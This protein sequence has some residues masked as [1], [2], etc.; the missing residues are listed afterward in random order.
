M[1][2]EKL[3]ILV[4]D[5]EPETRWFFN[6]ELAT[7]TGDYVTVVEDKP[8]ALE[9]LPQISPDVVVV[10]VQQDTDAE[11][12][13]FLTKLRQNREHHYT[14]IALVTRNDTPADVRDFLP[15]TDAFLKKPLDLRQWT[16]EES[17]L[18]RVRRGRDPR[19]TAAPT[20]QELLDKALESKD[21]ATAET[22]AK[23][24]LQ[25]S[26]GRGKLA[27]ARALGL[28]LFYQKRYLES[29]T[30]LERVAKESGRGEDWLSVATANAL[31]GR[32]EEMETCAEQAIRIQTQLVADPATKGKIADMLTPAKIYYYVIRAIC[33]GG[34]AKEAIRWL[35]RLKPFYENRKT[36]NEWLIAS[37]VFPISYMLEAIGLV[38][39]GAGHDFTAQDWMREF[40]NKLDP[41]GRAAMADL[42]RNLSINP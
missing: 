41:H 11:N 3:K 17:V 42:F 31:A 32:L 29:L 12:V 30:C 10:S 8:Q 18:T 16:D 24:I 21:Y 38:V 9:V 1:A 14:V 35:E 25:D 36:Q 37:G 28:A 2:S 19:A 33:E 34:N 22:L 20:P 26:Q 4:V 5:A 27:A 7:M 23:K 40:T 13:D 6:Q 15:F 39:Q